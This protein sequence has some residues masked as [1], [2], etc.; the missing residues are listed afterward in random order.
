MLLSTG[1]GAVIAYADYVLN[2]TQVTYD[3][4][5]NT[6]A[7]NEALDDLYTKTQEAQQQAQEAQ[8]AQQAQQALQQAQSDLLVN[9]YGKIVTGYG[10]EGTWRLF[11]SDSENA[12][13]IRDSIGDI[14]IDS[15]PGW[16]NSTLTT[17]NVSD[18]GKS[19]N[20]KYTY[21][22]SV[23]N[24]ENIKVVAALTDTTQWTAYAEPEV[25]NWAIG[26]PTLEMFVASYNA[27]HTIKI[28]Y[29]VSS[30]NGYEVGIN[31]SGGA[32][33]SFDATV[34]GLGN[35]SDL[36]NAIYCK[37]GT[38]DDWWLASPSGGGGRRVMRLGNNNGGNLGTDMYYQDYNAVRPLVQVPLSK[39]GNGLTI[40]SNYFN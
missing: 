38:D 37:S 6:I 35:S 20:S 30:S 8:E 32:V 7:V 29:R 40:T 24:Q 10:V 23:P 4:D 19:L 22:D 25:A 27:T 1:V 31:T 34:T 14:A 3:K 16:D 5:G 17:S 36:D 2:A 28:D 39:I 13:L 11:Y 26:A 12:Y 15:L 18:L 33:T 21:W 9:S